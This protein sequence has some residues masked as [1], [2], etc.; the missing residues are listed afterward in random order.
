MSYPSACKRLFA[1]VIALLL[2][3]SAATFAYSQTSGSGNITGTVTDSANAAVANAAVVIINIDTGVTRKLTTDS[4]GLYTANFLQPGHYEVLLGGD[5]FGKINR[6]NLLLTVGQTLTVDATLPPAS[7]STEVTVL[8]ETPILDPDKTEVSQTVGQEL[9][10]NLPVNSRN[11]SAFVLNTANVVPDGGS[12]LVSF[13]GISGLYN[14][15]YVDGA[16]NNQM[17]FSEARG[18]AS[19]APYVYSLDSIKE[20]QAET[21]NYSV[22]FGQA[23]GGQV[24]AITKSGTN[25]IHGDAFYYLRYPSLN[26][27]DP[28]TKWAAKFNTP[29]PQAAAFLLTQPIHQQHPVRWTYW[30]VQLIKDRLFYFFTYDGFRRV[31]KA[32]YYNNNPV[33]LTPTPSNSAGTVI[34]PTQCPT[35]ITAAQCTSAINFI[36]NNGTG[37]PSRYSKQNLFFPRLDWH[38][39]SKN[40]MFVNF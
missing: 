9:I 36:L 31:G 7:A 14:Q 15:N 19:G 20:F 30:R 13:R 35:T 38:I 2:F 22:E 34:S 10:S 6:K 5:T 17:L 1:N 24:N 4:A 27:L 28:Q 3:V 8:S 16:N 11:W 39:N 37:A 29:N 21:S 32:L 12:G 26:A 23:A 40:D 25:A 18:R 33:S